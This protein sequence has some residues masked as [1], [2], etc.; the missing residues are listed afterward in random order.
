[1]FEETASLSLRVI[2]CLLAP[3]AAAAVA[4]SYNVAALLRHSLQICAWQAL[5]SSEATSVDSSLDVPNQRCWK[6]VQQVS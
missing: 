1:M 3:A 2:L 4:T 6:V 5:K